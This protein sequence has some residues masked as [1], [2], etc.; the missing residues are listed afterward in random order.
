MVTSCKWVIKQTKRKHR[1]AN[2]SIIKEE[3]DKQGKAANIIIKGLR[4]IGENERTNILVRDFL[5]DKL[6]W[7]GCIHHASMIR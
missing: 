3:K 7:T 4:D 1:E 2:Q 5:K 6:K